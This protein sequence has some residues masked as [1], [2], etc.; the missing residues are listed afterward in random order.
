[1]RWNLHWSLKF[2]LLMAVTF[3]LLLVSYRYLVRNTWIGKALNGRRNP[4][5]AA[6]ETQVQSHA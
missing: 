1:M 5:A 3:G 2:P 6:P 4:P